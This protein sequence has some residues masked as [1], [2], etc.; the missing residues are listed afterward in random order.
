[1]AWVAFF[2]LVLWL[3]V[4]IYLF[5]R[6]TAQK[7]IVFSFIT[8]WLFLPPTQIPLSGIPDWSKT[9]ATVFSVSLCAWMKHAHRLLGIQWKWYDFPVFL[10]C[11]CPFV[12]SVTNGLGAYDGLSSVLDEL[13]RWGFPY[14][15]G[16]AFLG[17]AS[18]NRQLCLGIAVGGLLYVPLCMIE[19]RMS[20][21]LKSWVYGFGGGR[22]VDFSLRY[23]GYRPMV[24]L[25][26]GLE[27][28]WW[29]CCA[30]LASYQLWVS[31]SV[32]RLLGF[33][34]G[35]CTAGIAV[36]TVACKSTGALTQILMGFFLIYF[37]RF[38]KNTWLVWALVIMPPMYCLARPTGI[39][40]GERMVDTA[41][42]IFGADRAQ[43]LGFRFDNE[44]ILMRSAM[45]R[46]IFGWARSGGFNPPDASGKTAITDGLWI[47]VFGWMGSVGLLGLN[48][49]LLT[50]TAL[51]LRRFPTRTWLEAD[52]A[53]VTTLALILPLFMLDNL[54]NAML[55]PIYALAMGSVSGF[56]PNLRAMARTKRRGQAKQKP[57][58]P[59]PAS[60]T[61]PGQRG[62]R[63][64]LACDQA[65]DHAEA[66][67]L[68]A[69]EQD[70]P[71]D[72]QNWFHRALHSRQSASVARQTAERMDRQAT[73]HTLYARFLTR[74]GQIP[75]AIEERE[76][77]LKLWKTLREREPRAEF[78]RPTYLAN[79]NDLA[80][81]LVADKAAAPIELDRAILLAE[82]AV[83][84]AGEHAPFWNTLGI[85]RYRRGDYHKAI[86]ALSRSVS[87][88][89]E[90]GNAFDFYYLA[91]A[92]QALGYPT[93]A[94]DW[95]DRA[96]GWASRHPELGALLASV[97]AEAA[98]C[99]EADRS[100]G[101]V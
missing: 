62:P 63:D 101:E 16:R 3:P 21:M 32:K 7:A 12:S 38:T 41:A 8:A 75:I 34:M 98:E 55:N 86:H 31:G 65:A 84:S 88:S 26:T 57:E 11:L 94:A 13:F 71:E 74:Q 61:S 17:N 27:L 6:F 95:L 49:M 82:E 37:C 80:W 28:G 20:P 15:I 96:E 99:F 35:V 70:R 33:P 83:L 43:S 66:E 73:T 92:N 2:A 45:Q 100:S 68:T 58:A 10:Y 64:D 50:P 56:R 69:D 77:A 78:A 81:L 24:F 30:T 23:G 89:P 9:T 39:W 91:L 59:L 47:I 90:G 60:L 53:P 67:A 54:S 48:S 79:L 44:E 4:V 97:R 36:I 42:S 87:L 76:R 29:M 51:F 1:M 46:P 72:A 18:G 14:V 52:V 25:A 22:D 19:I 5:E 93:P 40:T 85:A